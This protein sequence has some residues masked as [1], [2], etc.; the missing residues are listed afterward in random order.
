MHHLFRNPRFRGNGWSPT[1][2]TGPPN[3]NSPSPIPPHLKPFSHFPPSLF[4]FSPCLLFPLGQ[5]RRQSLTL[6]FFPSSNSNPLPCSLGHSKGG[7]EGGRDTRLH[8]RRLFAQPPAPGGERDGEKKNPP[9]LL[10]RGKSPKSPFPLLP[11]LLFFRPPSESL[12]PIHSLIGQF[13]NEKKRREFAGK[14]KNGEGGGNRGLI[15]F[16]EFPRG[17][18]TWMNPHSDG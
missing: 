6:L 11:L 17:R 15:I 12:D 1:S 16:L 13:W 18:V 5:A 14:R 10:V 9:P 7:R 3:R 2:T 4:L 8:R